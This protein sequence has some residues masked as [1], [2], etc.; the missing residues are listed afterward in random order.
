MSESSSSSWWVYLILT[1]S[2][3][4]YTGIAKDTERRFQEHLATYEGR[5]TK[6]AK[7]FRGHKPLN[8]IYQEAAQNRSEATRRELMIKK[9]P[10][11]KKWA[12]ANMAEPDST[13][14]ITKAQ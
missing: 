6:G 1:E 13:D 7:F 12:L 4:I 8:I 3:L 14:V 9:L 2:E 11:D 10:R 5:G